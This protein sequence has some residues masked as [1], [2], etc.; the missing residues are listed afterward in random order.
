M[1]VNES[2]LVRSREPSGPDTSIFVPIV[3]ICPDIPDRS[4]WVPMCYPFEHRLDISGHNGI[5]MV[6]FDNSLYII[7]P[8]FL[9]PDGN[10]SFF[11]I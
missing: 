4:R 8:P 10:T 11:Y 3:P 1:F 6:I 7:L 2:R 9:S 5:P